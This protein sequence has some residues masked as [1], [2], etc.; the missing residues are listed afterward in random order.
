[1]QVLDS[2]L[3]KIALYN[4]NNVRK[5]IAR[6]GQLTSGLLLLDGRSR[7]GIVAVSGWEAEADVRYTAEL[8]DAELPAAAVVG[9][10]HNSG[11]PS[12]GWH[13]M[14]GAEPSAVGVGAAV[15]E[16]S[17]LLLSSRQEGATTDISAAESTI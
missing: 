4:S 16:S 14:V 5:Y 15:G 17:W 2:R 13:V 9:A 10:L 12:S 7:E 11:G 3:L 1:M 8:L 6:R